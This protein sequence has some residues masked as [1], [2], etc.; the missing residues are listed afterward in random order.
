MAQATVNSIAAPLNYERIIF[1]ADTACDAKNTR[2][3]LKKKVLFQLFHWISDDQKP[4][5]KC[6][7]DIVGLLK[8]LIAIWT[9]GEAFLLDGIR[10]LK[11]M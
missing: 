7:Q 10:R 2:M 3:F 8:E 9:S 6:D 5:K 11:T 1:A 4:S